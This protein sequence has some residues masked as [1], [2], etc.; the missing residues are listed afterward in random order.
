[1]ANNTQQITWSRI[2]RVL[3]SLDPKEADVLTMRFHDNMRV[4]SIAYFYGVPKKDIEERIDNAL[5][6]VH[7]RLTL[8]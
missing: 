5:S 8:N 4:D 7:M 1:M 3:D 6:N 2:E